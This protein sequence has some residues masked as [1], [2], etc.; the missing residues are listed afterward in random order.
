MNCTAFPE[1]CTA[2]LEIQIV[3]N[4]E[5]RRV[6]WG[7]VLGGVAEKHRRV[8]LLRPDLGRL[9]P[10]KIDTRDPEALRVPLLPGDRI[11]WR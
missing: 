8:E 3:V 4:G 11:K 9:A 6:L 1:A 5:S 7:S 2:S 10:V